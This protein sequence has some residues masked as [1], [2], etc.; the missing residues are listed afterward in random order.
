MSP[1]ALDFACAIAR[2]RVASAIQSAAVLHSIEIALAF[3]CA[4]QRARISLQ[5]A[6]PSPWT[7]KDLP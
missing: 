4:R 1:A 7:L 6:N 3:E 2:S 5:Q